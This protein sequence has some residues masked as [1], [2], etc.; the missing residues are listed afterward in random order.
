MKK[1][2]L[3]LLPCLLLAVACN[4]GLTIEQPEITHNFSTNNL[5]LER[6]VRTSEATRLDMTVCCL[7]GSRFSISPETH[8]KSSKGEK[9]YA[10]IG[11]E[12]VETGKKIQ[13]DSTGLTAVSLFFEPLADD[14]EA[15]S[16]SKRKC[17]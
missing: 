7:P 12:G 6:I 4:R 9:T 11:T 3:L 1:L 10:L 2:Y 16:L 5:V 14:E 15:F 8:L 13:S 17:F